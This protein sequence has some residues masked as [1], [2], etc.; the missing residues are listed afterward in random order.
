[1]DIFFVADLHSTQLNLFR[2]FY[3]LTNIKLNILLSYYYMKNNADFRRDVE[4][5]NFYT[6]KIML[7]SGAFTAFKSLNEKDTIQ[8]GRQYKIFLKTHKTFINNTFYRVFSFDYRKD[9]DGFDDNHAEFYELYEA[10]NKVC[11]VI[12]RLS[13]D[14]GNEEIDVYA[15]YNPLTIGIGQIENRTSQKNLSYLQ[16]TIEGINDVKSDCHLLGIANFEMLQ[17]LHGIATCDSSS[18]NVYAINGVVQTFISPKQNLTNVEPEIKLVK[19][20][21]YESDKDKTDYFENQSDEFK[22]SFFMEM[23]KVLRLEPEQFYNSEN[24][25]SRQLANL[26]YTHKIFEYLTNKEK[27]LSLGNI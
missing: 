6:N 9:K 3:K 22:N 25:R 18:W 15:E 24:I 16:K 1:M 2:S 14:K 21:K 23:N 5:I 17:N 27:K 13:D 20:Y 8:L 19:F 4:N 12:H 11:P 26:Y 10:Y 7:D